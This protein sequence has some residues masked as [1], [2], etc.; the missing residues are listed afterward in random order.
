MT[1]P[2]R[3][4]SLSNTIFIP[5]PVQLSCPSLSLSLSLPPSLPLSLSHTRLV[6]AGLSS[7]II[8]SPD[9][10]LTV[11]KQR[12]PRTMLARAPDITTRLMLFLSHLLLL[13]FYLNPVSRVPIRRA[14][15]VTA[16]THNRRAT[17]VQYPGVAVRHIRSEGLR[18]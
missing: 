10:W 3:A 9:S 17:A 1:P 8:T 4:R 5:P 16:A 6:Y 7:S 12:A 15:A 18:L 2:A 13:L 11:H 14:V